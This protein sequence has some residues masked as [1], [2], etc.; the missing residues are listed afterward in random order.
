M[1]ESIADCQDGDHTGHAHPAATGDG[2]HH[3]T[4]AHDEPG[5]AG[6]EDAGACAD[7]ACAS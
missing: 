7:D 1:S 5:C 6:D 2:H 3:H 4:D